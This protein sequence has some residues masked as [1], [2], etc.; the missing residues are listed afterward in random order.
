MGPVLSTAAVAAAALLLLWRRHPVSRAAVA[1]AA[2]VV[3]VVHALP[4]MPSIQ[5]SDCV[6]KVL[7]GRRQLAPP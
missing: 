2:L 6:S 1:R 4:R 3:R 7:L 5:R